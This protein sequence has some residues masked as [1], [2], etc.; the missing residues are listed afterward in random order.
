[1][2]MKKGGETA[3]GDD[4]E[5]LWPSSNVMSSLHSPHRLRVK[6]KRRMS[7]FEEGGGFFDEREGAIRR[8][9][10]STG[11]RDER[12]GGM[13]K[14]RGKSNRAVSK[15]FS[16]SKSTILLRRP[17]RRARVANEPSLR[18]LL[19]PPPLQPP[20]DRHQPEPFPKLPR[21]Q[22]PPQFLWRPWK[23]P[24]AMLSHEGLHPYSGRGGVLGGGGGRGRGRRGGR[25]PGRNEVPPVVDSQVGEKPSFA[26]LPVLLVLV[27]ELVALTA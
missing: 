7:D 16:S 14:E 13:S 18:T 19:Q 24:H 3:E 5:A 26:L 22:R 20:L 25:R 8:R 2:R 12:E 17:A 10:S 4:G 23:A 1:M 6:T 27:D 15:I 21:I 9:R 11:E